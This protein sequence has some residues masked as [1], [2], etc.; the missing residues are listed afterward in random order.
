MTPQASQG[1]LLSPPTPTSSPGWPQAG[2]VGWRQPAAGPGLVR[3]GPE[4]RPGAE[5][6]RGQDVWGEGPGTH[7]DWPP[8]QA[9]SS[10]RGTGPEP[11]GPAGG[12]PPHPST[13][14]TDG[15]RAGGVLNPGRGHH[16]TKPWPVRPAASRRLHCECARASVR[17]CA[18][19]GRGGHRPVGHLLC[20]GCR[21]QPGGLGQAHA[22]LVAV[23]DGVV[24]ADEDVTQDPERP[25]RRGDVHA[26]EAAQADGL[27]AL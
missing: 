17:V 19:G 8:N 20:R 10:G 9:G 6:P 25:A 13:R 2:S 27:P 12:P 3:G 26:H 5:A 11:G 21:L 15:Q 7:T 4:G 22:V 1:W 14:Q 24:A 16:R 23:E 18:A